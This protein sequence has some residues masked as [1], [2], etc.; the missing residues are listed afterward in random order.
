MP[1]HLVLFPRVDIY[2]D[3]TSFR[4]Y[5]SL[6]QTTEPSW[7][8]RDLHSSSL[9]RTGVEQ[10]GIPSTDQSGVYPSPPPD[11]GVRLGTTR[12]ANPW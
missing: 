2:S 6:G 5:E 4:S 8:L 11:L 1:L 3:K 9:S 12:E 7:S 10:S